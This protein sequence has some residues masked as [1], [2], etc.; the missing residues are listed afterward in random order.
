MRVIVRDKT[1]QLLSYSDVT[2][3]ITLCIVMILSFRAYRYM[4]IQT[5]ET[6]IRLLL[7]NQS[8]QNLHSCH[9]ICTF[10]YVRTGVTGNKNS[11]AKAQLCLQNV[12]NGGCLVL[13]FLV[14]FFCGCF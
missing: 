14:V 2:R 5:E 3:T 11:R 4:Y 10:V 9:S 13:F 8:D 6:M 1:D 7:S 12:W